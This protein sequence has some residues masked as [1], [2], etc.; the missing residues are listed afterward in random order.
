MTQLTNDNYGRSVTVETVDGED[1]Y[2]ITNAGTGSS[3]SINFPTGTSLSNVYQTINAM[4]EA[5]PAPTLTQVYTA[6]VVAAQNFGQQLAT[7]YAVQNILLGIT[8][9]GKTQALIDYTNNLSQC[10]YTGS[11]YAALSAINVMIADISSAKTN[12]SP[13]ITNDILYSYL[14][15]IQSYLGIALTPNPGP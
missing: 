3:F 13:F 12:L 14:N 6:V 5:P 4:G 9:S 2:T 7:Q 8:Q 1:V 11:L 15:Q 10:L